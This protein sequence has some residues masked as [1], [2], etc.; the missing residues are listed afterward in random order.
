MTV[1]T[2]SSQVFPSISSPFGCLFLL[3]LT[4]KNTMRKV[5]RTRTATLMARMTRKT[6]STRPATFEALGRNGMASPV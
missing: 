4:T 5:I 2:I 3:Y 1:Q 6:A